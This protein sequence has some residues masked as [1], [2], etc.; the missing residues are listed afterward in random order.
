M[1]NADHEQ[2]AGTGPRTGRVAILLGVIL[3]VVTSG[4]YWPMVHHPF[5]SIDDHEYIYEN[6]H[7]TSGVTAKGVAW[8]LTTG[9]A[10]NWHPVTWI[11]HMV[12]CNLFGV[13][14]GGHHLVNLVFHAVNTVLLFLL[15]RQMTGSLWRSAF[16]AAL[17]G[18][19]PMHVESVAWASERKDVLCAFFW[20]LATMA[21]VRF[22]R[23][24]QRKFYYVALVLF[25]LGLMSKPMLV[26]FPFVLLLLDLWPLRRVDL[27][28]LRKGEGLE[29]ILRLVREKIPF[30][31]LAF[32]SSA[33]TY[34]VQQRAMS[35][36]QSVSV[37]M[38]I[39][40]AAMSYARYLLKLF[41]PVDLAA[42]Y[43]YPKTWPW[44]WIMGAMLLLVGISV[45]AG[46]SIKTRPYILVGWLWFLGTLVPTIGLVQVGSQSMADRYTYIPAIGIFVAVAWGVRGW[47]GE[48]FAKLRGPLMAVGV[49][50]LVGCAALTHAQLRTWHSSEELFRHAIKVTRDNYIALD[51]L[52]SALYGVGGHD[53]EAQKLFEES[54]RI[55]PGYPEAQ[56][57]LGTVLMRQGKL[58]E[59]I[60]RFRN[61]LNKSPKFAQA[62]SNLGTALLRKGDL[63]EAE[64]AFTIA[65]DLQ[66]DDA[67]AYY[68]VA[69]AQ[70][71]QGRMVEAIANFLTALRLKPDYAAAHGN[72]GVAFMRTG[73]PDQGIQH[74]SDAVRL[75][76]DDAEAHFNFGQ[77]LLETGKAALAE[78]E[79]KR[80]LELNPN[81]PAIRGKLAVSLRRQKKFA[82]ATAAF[83]RVLS[84]RPDSAEMMNEF[85]WLL[86]TAEDEKFRDGT[87][88]V[89]LAE[90]AGELTQR[91][92]VVV[93]LTLGVAYAEAGRFA[94]AIEV[95]RS[96]KEAASQA[97]Q[98]YLAGRA[99]GLLES[100][101]AKRPIRE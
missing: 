34:L 80:A 33:V 95:T 53:E 43:P 21:Y 40:N 23:G 44:L 47:A 72:L 79:L 58:D 85:A 36:L 46:R 78:N 54:V 98:S 25:G 4:L 101:E 55:E 100:F 28:G 16:V 19:H 29:G 84:E 69:T 76:P 65:L 3:A 30:L 22:V 9:H 51:A 99:Q 17:F 59:A 37:L 56:Y 89:R 32:V 90:R 68:N 71:A 11:S 52:G 48:R 87:E 42:I 70:V 20:F 94:D 41:W 1:E 13:H 64:K 57:D 63:A 92:V 14:P 96:A 66:R 77:A 97:R 93:L 50:V 8:A 31:A 2:L 81:D 15:L 5:I 67:E 18:W 74:L 86:A 38:R 26:T 75:S 73:Q 39:E 45:L 6:P 88:A 12:D 91:K 82:E 35:S 49:G 83:K 24:K 60:V 7:V 27:E 62:H 10:S 61:A